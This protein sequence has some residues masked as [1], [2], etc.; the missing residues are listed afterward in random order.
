MTT[1]FPDYETA[2][3]RAAETLIK[4]HIDSAPVAPLPVLKSL[5]GVIVLSFAEMAESAGMDRQNVITLF[6]DGNHDAVTTA[7]VSDGKLRYVVAYNQRLPFYML[8]RALAREL[9]HIMLRHDGTRTETVRTEEAVCFARHFLCPRP[10]V[11]LLQESDIPVT[12]EL[13]GNITGCYERCLTGIRRTP[14][15]HVPAELNRIIKDQFRAYVD[16]F[17]DAYSILAGGDE[18]AAADFGTFMDNYID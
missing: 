8:Q 1:T 7:K 4:F 11:K 12:V 2:A 5:R 9:G 14:G 18:S 6:G 13:I 3:A 16:N 10:L 17:I 15:A